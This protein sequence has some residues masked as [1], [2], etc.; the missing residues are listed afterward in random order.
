VDV[1]KQ[2]VPVSG[3][4]SRSSGY[5]GLAASPVSLRFQTRT[6]HTT[7][8]CVPAECGERTGARSTLASHTYPR[9]LSSCPQARQDALPLLCPKPYPPQQAPQNCTPTRAD[10]AG[11]G[12]RPPSPGSALRHHQVSRT[13]VLEARKR[14]WRHGE[15]Q[16]QRQDGPGPAEAKA[17]SSKRS[18]STLPLSS[19]PAPSPVSPSVLQNSLQQ[20][21]AEGWSDEQVR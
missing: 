7:C 9:G 2:P 17:P 8:V 5:L 10:H 6:Q 1:S 18:S 13:R 19:L 4:L 21:K 3:A 12:Q 11:V 20:R 15:R 14:L 16:R